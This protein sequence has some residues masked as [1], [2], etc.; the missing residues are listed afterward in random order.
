[1]GQIR[2][3]RDKG[4]VKR[5]GLEVGVRRNGRREEERWQETGDSHYVHVRVYMHAY[6]YELYT[7][8]HCVHVL[9]E[10]KIRVKEGI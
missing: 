7:C 1:M 8:M 2:I 4:G 10:K 3:L 5:K 6:V 9:V